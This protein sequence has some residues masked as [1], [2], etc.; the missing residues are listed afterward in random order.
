MTDPARPRAVL[1]TPVV[2]S[3]R[4]NGLAMRAGLLLTGLA[5][6]F[7]VDVA[8]APLPP[9]DPTGD[10]F[11][12]KLVERLVVLDDVSGEQT[13]PV[14]EAVALLST[15]AAPRTH[16]SSPAAAIPVPR[17][18]VALGGAVRRVGGRR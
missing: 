16:G 11:T 18:S 3:D 4:G 10:S 13:D 1:L 5:H 12:S 2:P 9:A 8:V 7:S 14:A 15:P 17:R 6:A